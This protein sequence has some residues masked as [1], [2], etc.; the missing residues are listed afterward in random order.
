MLTVLAAAS[1]CAS[2]CSPAPAPRLAEG[3]PAPTATALAADRVVVPVPVVDA[4]V[5][6]SAAPTVAPER[7]ELGELGIDV[8]VDVVGVAA[9]GQMEIPEDALRAGWYRFG[10]TPGERGA[11][12]IAAHAGSF[13]TPR[14][15]FFDLNR[16]EPGMIVDVVMADGARVEFEIET[17][18]LLTKSDLDLGPYFTRDGAPRLVLI[19]CGGEWDDAAQSYRS[20]IVVTARLADG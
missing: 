16:A 14:G 17:V 15:P 3:V 20:N 10:S 1:L 8:P 2:A 5:P 4:T 12:V 9:D 13:V 18:E 11:A 19:T 6:A 7:L